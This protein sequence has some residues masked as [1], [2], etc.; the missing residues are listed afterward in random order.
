MSDNREQRSRL[1]CN[2]S[3][4][5]LYAGTLF[6]TLSQPAIILIALFLTA[7]SP[8]YDWRAVSGDEAP[9]TVLM[10]DKPSRLSREIQLGQQK[11]IMHMTAAKIDDVKFVVGAV[12]MR[13]ATEAQTATAVIKNTLLKNMAGTMTNEKMT[14]SNVD[15]KLTVNDEFSAFSSASFTRMSGRLV[16]RDVWAFEV[17]VVGP[18][19][20]MKSEDVKAAVDMFLESFRPA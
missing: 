1:G 16:A 10:P 8:K 5:T 9:Y 18:E 11:V 7:C 6:P 19:Q 20:M 4:I 14:V 12:K 15:G 2:P 17:L 3:V 13:D